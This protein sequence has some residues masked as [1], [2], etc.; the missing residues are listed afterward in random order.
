MTID[1]VLK[2]IED[3]VESGGRFL[4]IIGERKGKLLYTLAKVT[5][6]KKILD[7]GTLTGYSALL[8]AKA[9]GTKGRIVTV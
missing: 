9:V 8:L 7:L 3:E 1:K 6:A 4:P 5:N 2:E